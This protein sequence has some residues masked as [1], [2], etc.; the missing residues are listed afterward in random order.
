MT[1]ILVTGAAGFVGSHSLDALREAPV[2]VI[3]ACRRPE[4]LPDWFG[5]EVRAGDMRDDA[6]VDALPE[7]VD[8][9]IPA[10]ARTSPYGHAR[11]ERRLHLDPTLRFLDALERG[12]APAR[13]SPCSTCGLGCS[14]AKTTGSACCRS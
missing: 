11:A 5:G 4:R 3:A 9:V 8:G 12:G 13:T 10:A 2:E 1:R 6:Y 7:G 14:W